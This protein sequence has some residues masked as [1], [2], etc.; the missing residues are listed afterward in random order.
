M[1]E[2]ALALALPAAVA[3]YALLVVLAA[4]ADP[5]DGHPI[6]WP[7]VG[8]FFVGM[9]VVAVAVLSPLD[10][11][12]HDQLAGHMVQHLLLV[13]V[14]APL[15]A[16]GRPIEV[17]LAAAGRSRRVA[18][19]GAV[20][21]IAAAITQVVVLLVWHIPDVYEAAARNDA[22]HGFEHLSLL[23]TSFLL[24]WLLLLTAGS[25]RGGAIVVL[26]VAS[27]PPMALGVGLTL[28]RTPWYDS[29]R[30]L[31]DQQFAGVWMWAYGGAAA[32]VG[33]VSLFASWMLDAA[34]SA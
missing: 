30:S 13:A 33:G 28:A 4:R 17:A 34:A 7:T 12:A 3:G 21:L 9:A 11:M 27:F 25:R 31:A 15:L 20:A 22:V 14:A 6:G 26:F 5:R 24:W 1:P 8:A 29:Y 32:V 18:V 10:G 2:V 16:A 19:P 23:A